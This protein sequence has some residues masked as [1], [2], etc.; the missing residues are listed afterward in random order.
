MY[1]VCPRCGAV[2]PQRRSRPYSCARCY[3]RDRFLVSM[4][5]PATGRPAEARM[6][7]GLAQV[8]RRSRLDDR[9]AARP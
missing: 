9:T 3:A 1:L 7:S 4:L 6:R 8:R 5:P 2:R